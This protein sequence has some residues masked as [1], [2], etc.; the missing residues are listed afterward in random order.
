MHEPQSVHTYA[1][2]VSISPDRISYLI[3]KRRAYFLDIGFFTNYDFPG[4]VEIEHNAIAIHA[5]SVRI[6]CQF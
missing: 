2:L 3:G 1:I 4:K 6:V 5:A